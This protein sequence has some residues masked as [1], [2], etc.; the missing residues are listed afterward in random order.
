MK[1]ITSCTCLA[2]ALACVLAGSLSCNPRPQ[3]IVLTHCEQTQQIHVYYDGRLFTSYF[4][5][6]DQVDKPV[7]YPVYTARGTAV[8]RGFPL[9]PQPGERI[10]HP[11]HVGI[12]FN[13][14]DVNGLDFWNNSYAI[15][16]ENKHR[17]GTIRHRAVTHLAS[18]PA[19]GELSVECD[20]IDHAGR[21]LLRETTHFVFTGS[22]DNRLIYRTT[23]LEAQLDTVA[24]TDNKEGLLA[25]RVDRAF[26]EPSDRAE[27][28][29]GADSLPADRPVVDN[30][31]V[32]GVYRNSDGLEYER[33]A[34]G[35]PA[36]W[37]SLSASKN[38]EPITIALIDHPGNPGYPAHAHARG[39]GLFSLNNMGSRAFDPEA[40]PFRHVLKRNE[41][42]TFKHCILIKTNGYA[43][44]NELNALAA[45]MH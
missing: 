44:D 34:W 31:G 3:G 23:I 43:T 37:L 17:Y 36:R 38:G 13:F 10:D 2:A 11:H 15:A 22:G 42:I 29:V 21:T 24:F 7:L 20:W 8:T 39:Y 4:Y 12:W 40:A 5:N 19:Q 30:R 14:G 25:I 18:S 27:L 41:I 35:K 9:H 28:R 26:E 45:K 33:R 16:P 6:A 32:G 1:H